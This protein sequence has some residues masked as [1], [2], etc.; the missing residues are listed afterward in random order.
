VRAAGGNPQT[1]P[2]VSHQF[3]NSPVYGWGNGMGQIASMIAPALSNWQARAQGM[4]HIYGPPNYAP[5]GMIPAN[6]QHYMLG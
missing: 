3:Q 2:A 4:G 1:T 6:V 5:G